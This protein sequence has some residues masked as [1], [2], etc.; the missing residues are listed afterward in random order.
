MPNN[1]GRREFLERFG[2][3]AAG[4][5]AGGYQATAQ[6]YPANETVQIGLIGVG[7][8]CLQLLE[9]LR[10]IPGVK[11]TAVCD[12]WDPLLERAKGVAE[13]G[14]LAT[15][16][17]EEILASADVDAV[18]IATPD[19]LHVPITIAAVKA[20]KDVYVEKP[21][22]HDRAEGQAAIDAVKQSGRIVQVGMQQRSM[23][24]LIE[25]REIIRSG[26]TGVIR[27][28]H[29]T[30][31]RN[32]ERTARPRVEIDPATVDWQAFLG[33]APSQP[34][35]P[36]KFRNWRFFW[37]FGGGVFT[38][39]MVHYIDV[40]HWFLG[41]EH[42]STAVSIG[43][44]FTKKDE[45][46][47]PD[48][49]Q[50]L[51]QYADPETQ[52]YFE[53]TFY[54][55]RN[56]AMMEYMGSEATLYCDRGRYELHPE[57]GKSVAY[58]ELILGSGGRGQDFYDKPNG[59]LLHLGNWLECIRTRNTPNAPV[60][61]GVSAANAAHLANQALRKSVVARWG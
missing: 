57:P 31:N 37:D 5:V 39:L 43:N 35:D 56:A 26:Q 52:V 34:F 33:N 19:H 8:R 1:F 54:N 61:A 58:K 2:I 23:P 6:G 22:T 24:H 18:L 40:A 38:D 12:V 4:L 47:T 44:W 49:V 28:V 9:S 30:W 21:F 46:E 51:M 42:P 32:M 50:T 60:E 13:P 59:E 3:G 7:G 15:R 48:T 36:Y 55:A 14:A 17:Y 53:G 11:V 41:L 27:K 20:G 10:T 16:R 25:A 29:L 45:W